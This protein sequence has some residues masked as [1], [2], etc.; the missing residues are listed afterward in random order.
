MVSM[1]DDMLEKLDRQARKESRARS[2]LLR[3][4]VRRHIAASAE[5]EAERPKRPVTKNVTKRS[6]EEDL[7]ARRVLRKGCSPLR[8][9]LGPVK[10][11]VDMRKVLKIGKKLRGLSREISESRQDRAWVIS[12]T[13]ARW[14]NAISTRRGQFTFAGFFQSRKLSIYQSFLTP[15]EITSAFYRRHRA[16]EISAEELSVVLKAYAIHSDETYLLIPYSDFMLELAGSLIARYPLR[17]LDGIQLASALWIRDQVSVDAA[18]LVFLSSDDR[19]NEA[20][21]REHLEA[22]NP[23]TR[24]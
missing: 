11:P 12:P 1:P 7:L 8:T 9:L 22:I 16:G 15:L 17:A 13:P 23:E 18:Q 4:A 10:G 2:E 5:S 6:V 14:Q 19:L 24:S 3:E 20:A 21:R